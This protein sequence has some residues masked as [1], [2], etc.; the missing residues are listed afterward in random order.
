MSKSIARNVVYK[1][2]LN[3]FNII[4]PIVIGAYALR[5]MG[6]DLIGRINFSESIYSYFM[7]FAG[8]GINTYGLRELSR[9]R[10]DKEKVNQLFTNLF[11]IGLIT[12]IIILLAYFAFVNYSYI[13]TLRYPV[14]LIYG[15]NISFNIFYV[16]WANEA[17]ERYDFITIKTIIIRIIYIVLLFTFI[18]SDKD[19]IKYV[20]LT[21]LT[22]FLN[23][24]VSFA[25]IKKDI[26][27]NFKDIN[28]KK[29]IRFLLVIIIMSNANILYTSLDRIMLGRYLGDEYVAFYGVS[30]SIMII[31]NTLLLSIVYVTIPRLSNVI[32]N[33]S[34]ENYESLLNKICKNYF[35]FLFPAVVGMFVLAEEIVLLYAKSKFIP[36]IPVVRVFAIY[37]ITAGMDSILINQVIYVK[38]KEKNIIGVIAGFGVLNLVLNYAL[39][40]ANYFTPVTAIT[41][42]LIANALL[43]ATEYWYAKKR[44]KVKMS[45]FSMDKIKYFIIALVF[46]PITITIKKLVSSVILVALLG[47]SINSIVYFLILLIIKDEV[48]YGFLYKFKIIKENRLK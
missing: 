3:I 42:T 8:F 35:A 32:A 7:I 41:T 16:E 24:I 21:S 27:F 47:V 5:I 33:E 29:H 46:V 12:N 43:V 26:K 15:L 36:A 10:E 19:F 14:L 22:M 11:L 2:L 4:V 1:V 28:L 39:V 25:Y 44:L 48:L 30:Q 18:K 6:P 45:M 31:I 34:E 17:L 20:L 13:G 23:Y 9:I 38:R 40:Y 37:M